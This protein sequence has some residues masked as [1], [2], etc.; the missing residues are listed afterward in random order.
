MQPYISPRFYSAL[1][2]SAGGDASNARL[3]MFPGMQHCRGG[4]GPDTA[5]L[6]GAITNWVEGGTP[7]NDSLVAAKLSAT[8]AVALTRPLCAYPRVPMYVGGDP[9]AAGSFA[10]V[11]ANSAQ[12]QHDE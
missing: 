4:G 12:A 5:D 3:Y 1:Q 10:C 6:V 8:G 7:P 9:N 2:K 11:A